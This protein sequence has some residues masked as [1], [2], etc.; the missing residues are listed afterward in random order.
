[1]FVGGLVMVGL[2]GW[3]DS[4]LVMLERATPTLH[5]TTH[6]H[7]PQNKPLPPPLQVARITADSA[8][9]NAL[10]SAA[11]RAGQLQRAFNVVEQMLVS[12]LGILE[13]LP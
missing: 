5:T 2:A 3:L 4:W 13:I 7:S 9:W 6:P 8:V 11:G 12:A 10:V 1:M